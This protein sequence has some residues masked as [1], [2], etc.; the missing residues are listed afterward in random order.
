MSKEVKTVCG[1]CTAFC[2]IN[3]TIDNDIIHLI[4]GRKT[5]PVS[6]GHVCP[7]GKALG[8]LY[9]AEDLLTNPLKKNSKGKWNEIS[10]D[11]ALDYVS[12][13]LQNMKNKY[14][15]DSVAFYIGHGGI[16]KEIVPFVKALCEIFGTSNFST[17]GSHCHS[18]KVLSNLIT[19][20]TYPVPDYKNSNCIVLWG[21]NPSK[22]LHPTMNLINKSI[23]KGAK[24]IVID[25]YKTEPARKA[26]LHLQVRPGSDGAIALG[27]LNII[28]NEQLYDKPFVNRWTNGFD[29]LMKHVEKYPPKVVEEI[30]WVPAEK[31]IEA[32]R[33]YANKGPSC[34]FQGIAL[35][36]QT[37]GFQ[38]L[39]SISIL[40]AITGN[41]DVFGGAFFPH[42]PDF[43]P[44]NIEKD[45]KLQT[46]IGEREYPLF[47]KYNNAQANIF[48]KAILNNMP[49]SLKG[50]VVT[51]SNPVLTWPDSQKVEEALKGLKFL[52]VLDNFITATAK[53]A[54]IIIP[55]T[56]MW[57][58]I[59]MW[60][61]SSNHNIP[62]VGISNKLVQKQDEN[63]M[64]DWG[65]F[66]ELFI[67]MG[68]G[69]YIRWTDVKDYINYRLEAL[70]LDFDNLKEL[71]DGFEFSRLKGKKYEEEGFKTPSGK[72]DLYSDT[73]KKY[74]YD[75]LPTYL[76]PKESPYSRKNLYNRYPMIATTGKRYLNYIHSRFR[77]IESLR[78]KVPEPFCE[79]HRDKAQEYNL[80]EGEKVVIESLRGSIEIKVKINNYINPNVIFIP[81]GWE[82]A[83]ANILIDSEE[84]DPVTGFPGSR[85]FL[86][87]IKKINNYTL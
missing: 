20:G 52:V 33:M 15:A 76:E 54:N 38:T 66:K 73:L 42:T 4:R 10:W 47:Y 43:T 2:G 74:G 58:N 31:I 57:S 6:D 63:Q 64:T 48:H 12:V 68:Y 53:H 36:L 61:A 7:K 37:N 45:K 59:E 49:Y 26:N 41:I 19:L 79:I 65:F 46:G 17:A 44:L 77:N 23:K 30:T 56:L 80:K 9:Q 75:P 60:E 14:G 32:A 71:P 16:F 34:I 39:R 67:K 55:T 22:S 18:S 70:D 86:A 85:S 11:E 3:V 83:N 84:L 21:T 5:H 50:M 72:V 28:I 29:K 40:Q 1:L 13:N 78:E 8:E 69:N 81:H 27:I 25:P 87:A 51:G 24:L 82:E 35:E 62:R